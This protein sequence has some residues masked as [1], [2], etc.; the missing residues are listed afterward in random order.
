[1]VIL[2]LYFLNVAFTV[3]MQDVNMILLKFFCLAVILNHVQRL[4]LCI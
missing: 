3:N 4:G 1:M 2:D